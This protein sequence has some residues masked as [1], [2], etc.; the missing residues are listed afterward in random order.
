MIT[1]IHTD[2]TA[3]DHNP[4]PEVARVKEDTMKKKVLNAL[5]EE[6]YTYAYAAAYH[7]AAG[8][9][10]AEGKCREALNAISAIARAV[11]LKEGVDYETHKT[12]KVASG[13]EFTFCALRAIK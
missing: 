3:E 5:I 13:H 4:A 7:Q 11:G 9:H 2:F 1:M 12:T 10:E 6:Y 8:D